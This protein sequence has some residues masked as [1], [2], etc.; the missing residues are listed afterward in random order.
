ME[1]H[2]Q[3]KSDMIYEHKVV[4]QGQVCMRPVVHV[5][6]VACAGV[7]QAQSPLRTGGRVERRHT[8]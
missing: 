5:L 2:I 4:R 8:T 6:W 3:I 7:I 1:H